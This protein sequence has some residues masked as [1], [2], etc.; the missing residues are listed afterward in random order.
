MQRQLQGKTRN[1]Q[2]WGFDVAYI[3]GLM[4][5]YDVFKEGSQLL[6]VSVILAWEMWHDNIDNKLRCARPIHAWL[7]IS[8]CLRICSIHPTFHPKLWWYQQWYTW[9]RTCLIPWVVIR[10][11]KKKCKI[12]IDRNVYSISFCIFIFSTVYF[13]ETN[14]NSTTHISPKYTT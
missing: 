2:F 11:L 14:T 5:V 6:L 12:I 7:L 8:N 13:H 3:R 4:V 1:I 10:N 9:S